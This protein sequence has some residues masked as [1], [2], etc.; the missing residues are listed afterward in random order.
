MHPMIRALDVPEQLPT[1]QWD[2]SVDG[3]ARIVDWLTAAGVDAEFVHDD[4][5]HPWAAP[6]VLVR[7]DGGVATVEGGMLVA[8]RRLDGAV[9]VL[10]YAS[11]LLPVS[12]FDAE[13]Q[14]QRV[15]AV[16][17]SPTIHEYAAAAVARGA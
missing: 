15:P 16:D 7:T 9:E 13:A 6:T 5:K 1:M 8:L 3:A 10:I 11:T 14:K 12:Y 4:P 17:G 2:G